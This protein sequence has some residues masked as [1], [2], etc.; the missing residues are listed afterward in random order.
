M[1]SGGASLGAA[2][3]R[4]TPRN[5]GSAWRF[6]FQALD[7]KPFNTPILPPD[8]PVPF[9]LRLRLVCK[10]VLQYRH[11]YNVDPQIERVAAELVSRL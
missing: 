11:M 5:H 3:P 4:T 7:S 2:A 6:E 10:Q 8:Q 9:D 1:E